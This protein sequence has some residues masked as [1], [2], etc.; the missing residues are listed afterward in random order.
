MDVEPGLLAFAVSD[1]ENSLRVIK[2]DGELVKAYSIPGF[3][4]QWSPDGW[5]MLDRDTL[6]L[7]GKQTLE[8]E[9]GQL[10]T[11]EPPLP[12][13][14]DATW[15]PD[16]ET[17]VFV[18]DEG[19]Y[20]AY[21]GNTGFALLLE[22][23]WQCRYVAWSPDGEKIAFVEKD[24]GHT[25][26]AEDDV[27]YL[28]ILDVVDKTVEV[29][30]TLRSGEDRWAPQP[31]VAKP[32]WSPDSTKLAFLGALSQENRGGVYTL[33]IDSGELR[34]VVP[35][36]GPTGLTRITH[37]QREASWSPEGSQIAYAWIVEDSSDIF[38]N[39]IRVVDIET[40][41]SVTVWRHDGN[42]RLSSG[43]DWRGQ[44]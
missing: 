8:W 39:E 43:P 17:F 21:T 41:K 11:I 24:Y 4:P 31:Y 3:I 32:D 18:G 13:Y 28:K 27:Y 20:L 33:D 23:T 34:L 22:C 7:E 37:M 10:K 12:G 2:T 9:T 38:Y 16:G 19:L 30:L 1:D 29:P 36:P 35:D 6:D 15:G 40:L 42:P 14:W 44:P 25:H 5:L 26:R